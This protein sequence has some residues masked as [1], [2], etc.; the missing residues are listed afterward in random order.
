MISLDLFDKSEKLLLHLAQLW[1]TAEADPMLYD[2]LFVSNPHDLTTMINNGT[3][4]SD[5]QTFLTDSRVQAY[6]DK[7]IYTQAGII[8]NKLMSDSNATKLSQAE[9]ARLNTAIKYRDDHRPDFAIPTQYIYTYV[10]PTPAEK[11]FLH[12]DANDTSL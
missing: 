3:K 7:I 10:P 9:S 12:K 5:W 1:N 4:Y 11:E 8:I 2:E 6:I